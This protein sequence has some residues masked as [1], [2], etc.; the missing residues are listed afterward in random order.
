MAHY[1]GRASTSTST[2]KAM[3]S[4]WANHKSHFRQG[5]D[6]CAMTTHLLHYHR[7]EDPQQFITIQILQ[8]SPNVEVA[9]Q[10]EKIWTR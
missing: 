3:G 7:E 5:H 4:R 10:L 2:V 1:V 9:K 6:F 8:S